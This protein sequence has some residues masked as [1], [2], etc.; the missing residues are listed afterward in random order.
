[1]TPPSLGGLRLRDS[2]VKLRQLRNFLAVLDEGSLRRAAEALGITEPALSKSIRQLEM[3]LQVPLLDRG[4]RGMRPT[5]YGELLATHAR[6]A[7]NELEQALEGLGELRGHARGVVRVGSGPSCAMVELPRAM[8]RFYARW[9]DI[10][11]I[12]RQGLSFELVPQILRGELDFAIVSTDPELNDP[13]LD[14]QPLLASPVEIVAREGHPLAAAGELAPA[15]LRGASWVLPPRK[16]PV[17]SN[18]ERN[19][20]RLGLGEVRLVAESSSILLTLSLLAENDN[21]GLLPSAVT[22]FQ[23]HHHRFVALKV[24]S[25]DWRREFSLVQRARITRS[26]AALMLVRELKKVC[27]ELRTSAA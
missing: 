12:V 13:D 7:C 4:P 18:F 19:H 22:L 27:G 10:R 11:V 6:T 17:R 21:L 25:F 3:L 15:A 26:P 16:D 24:P 23:H 9:P 1:M 14:V 8:T 20:A 5:A 2:G